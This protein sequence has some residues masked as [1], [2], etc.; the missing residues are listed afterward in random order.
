[1]GRENNLT[2]CKDR[3]FEADCN[4]DIFLNP[5]A[6]HNVM[7]LFILFSMHFQLGDPSVSVP[8]LL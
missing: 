1:M 8:E 3:W 2:E 7:I 4:T 6:E 5:V